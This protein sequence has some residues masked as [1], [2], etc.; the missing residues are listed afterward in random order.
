MQDVAH[1][2]D[3]QPFEP[4]E[5]LTHR[6][7]IEQSLSRVLVLSVTGVD[8][9][10]FC[11]TRDELWS[12]D[13]RVPDDDHVGVVGAERDRRVLRDSPL[14]TEEPLDLIDIVSAESRF[15][16]SSKLDEVRV[17]DS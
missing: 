8:D 17:D 14:S 1:D 5:R 2:R 9:M 15:A 11:Y 7:E 16:A 10:G 12:A 4:A 6:V 13:L 3:V